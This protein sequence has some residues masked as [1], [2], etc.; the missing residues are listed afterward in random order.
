MSAAVE[1]FVEQGDLKA[2]LKLLERERRAALA[3]GDL[4][5]VEEVLDAAKTVYHRAE[6]KRQSEAGRIAF[7]A[8]QNIR[9]LGRQAG[10][11]L[12][13]PTAAGTRSG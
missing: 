9:Q 4:A 12:G 11:R 1:S 5:A 8:Q 10:R 13:H 2:A 6:G 3:R 7:A